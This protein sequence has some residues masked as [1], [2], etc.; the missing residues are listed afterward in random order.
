MYVFNKHLYYVYI[1][2]NPERTVLYTGVTNNLWQR[3][4]EHWMNRGNS[5]TFA[6]KYY[7]YNL[8]Y[9]E[10]FQYVCNAIAREKEIKGWRRDKKLQLIKTRNPDWSFLNA[11]VCGHWPPKKTSRRRY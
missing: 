7:C 8:I 9:F 3:L 2:T 4:T 1:V 5:K 11:Q 6:G 10:E